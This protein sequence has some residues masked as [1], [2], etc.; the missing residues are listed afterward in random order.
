MESSHPPRRMNRDLVPNREGRDAF[1]GVH[2]RCN[3]LNIKAD[4]VKLVPTCRTRFMG[5]SHSLPCMK[6]DLE[7]RNTRNTR[8]TLSANCELRLSVHGTLPW[9]CRPCLEPRNPSSE[10]RASNSWGKGGRFMENTHPLPRMNRSPEPNREGRDAFHGVRRA[11]H[12]VRQCGPG[13]TG[14][15][16]PD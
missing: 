6:R 8:K 13:G 15:Y 7:P 10:L 2:R 4:E 16:L 12:R 11:I 14:P 3:T 5:S 9:S 1:H